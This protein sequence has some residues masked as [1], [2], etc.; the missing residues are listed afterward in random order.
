M[1]IANDRRTLE[2]YYVFLDGIVDSLVNRVE[3]AEQGNAVRTLYGIG[4]TESTPATSR[5][6]AE[7]PCEHCGADYGH[8]RS[9]PLLNRTV[10]EE[11]SKIFQPTEKD[12]IL[13]HGLG[14]SLD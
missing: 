12:R 2:N 14:I 9:C 8:K 6:E 7:N 1:Y 10:A 11:R 13:A 3:R 5:Y 4:N